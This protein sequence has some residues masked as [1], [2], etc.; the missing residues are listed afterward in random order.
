MSEEIMNPRIVIDERFYSDGEFKKYRSTPEQIQQNQRANEVQR[1]RD[2]RARESL[3]D[4]SD[5]HRNV[6]QNNAQ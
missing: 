3:R 6:N 5:T 4:N 2:E 1:Q